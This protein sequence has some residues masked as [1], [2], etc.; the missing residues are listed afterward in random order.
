MVQAG[1]VRQPNPVQPGRPLPFPTAGT[2]I[3]GLRRLFRGEA[4]QCQS[5]IVSQP[6]PPL[7]TCQRRV[8][9]S[10]FF[11]TTMPSILTSV[12]AACRPT[13]ARQRL[14]LWCEGGRAQMPIFGKAGQPHASNATPTPRPLSAN[15]SGAS[16]STACRL[17]RTST[18]T[19]H[20]TALGATFFPLRMDSS[21]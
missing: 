11:H 17:L 21:N 5:L 14:W 9:S 18:T 19:T 13:N 6:S 8:T 16:S 20:S 12:P 2:M 7:S 1:S 15:T 3:E 4:T 10:S